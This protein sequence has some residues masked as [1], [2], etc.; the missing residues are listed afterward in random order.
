MESGEAL[1]DL[2]TIAYELTAVKEITG[3]E[4]PTVIT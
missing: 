2:F 3:M 4:K 1:K